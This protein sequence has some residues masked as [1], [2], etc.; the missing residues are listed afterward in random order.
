MAFRKS[1]YRNCSGTFQFNKLNRMF[2][3]LVEPLAGFFCKDDCL[4]PL[5]YSQ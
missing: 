1:H 2:S 5:K 4:N 3:K